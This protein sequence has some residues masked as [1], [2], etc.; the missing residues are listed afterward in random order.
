MSTSLEDKVQIAYAAMSVA[1]KTFVLTPPPQKKVSILQAHEKVPEAYRP[2][3]RK[4]Q[5]GDD[6]TCVEYV[7]KSISALKGGVGQVM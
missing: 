4:L 3:F 7:K 5:M 6:Q 1:D 2:S